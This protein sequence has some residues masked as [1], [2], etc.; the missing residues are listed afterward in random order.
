MISG[1]NT[2]AAFLT[3]LSIVD[4]AA[5]DLILP[6]PPSTILNLPPTMEEIKKAINQSSSNK[7]PGM[8]RIPAEIYKA[9][10][11]VTLEM[12]HSLILNIWEEEDRCN[13]FRD[14]TVVLLFK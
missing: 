2:S 11:P 14:T 12:F 8:D 5:L 3:R 1:E 6:K 10:G 7:A 13:D 9:A 4:P